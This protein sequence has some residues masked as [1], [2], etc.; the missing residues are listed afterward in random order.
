[1]SA[2]GYGQLSATTVVFFPLFFFPLTP[3]ELFN[4]AVF[5]HLAPLPHVP[6]PYVCR[7]NKPERREAAAYRRH[8]L[9]T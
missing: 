4:R 9:F 3:R 1:M 2:H 6:R 5:I 8:T 7:E